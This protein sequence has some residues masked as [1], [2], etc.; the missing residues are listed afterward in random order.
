MQLSQE[1]IISI[2]IIIRS[3]SEVIGTLYLLA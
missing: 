2:A 3:A 1:I